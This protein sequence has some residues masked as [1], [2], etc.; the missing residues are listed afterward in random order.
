M[1]FNFHANVVQF[2]DLALAGYKPLD[3]LVLKEQGELGMIQVALLNLGEQPP[4]PFIIAMHK[5]GWRVVGELKPRPAPK[6]MHL[7]DM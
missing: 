1:E 3:P 6:P 5:A 2:A 4:T 7:F